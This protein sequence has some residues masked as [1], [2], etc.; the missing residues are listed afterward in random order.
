MSTAHISTSHTF[1]QPALPQ[2]HL[3]AIQRIIND[4][5]VLQSRSARPPP[6]YTYNAHPSQSQSPSQSEP[7]W[8]KPRSV[9]PAIPPFPSYD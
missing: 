5:H 1:L 2:Q 6:P 8:F 4:A 7:V 9:Y 3:A